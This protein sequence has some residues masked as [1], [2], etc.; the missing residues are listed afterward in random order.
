MM[1]L[2]PPPRS[3]RIELGTARVSELRA[4]GLD[5]PKSPDRVMDAGLG[6]ARADERRSGGNPAG[7]VRRLTREARELGRNVRTAGVGGHGSSRRRR[8]AAGARLGGAGARRGSRVRAEGGE[9]QAGG[10]GKPAARV[11]RSP[12]DRRATAPP[13]RACLFEHG[14]PHAVRCPPPPDLRA[15]PPDVRASRASLPLPTQP[16]AI[17][18]VRAPRRHPKLCHQHPIRG[19]GT[20]GL[21]V[22]R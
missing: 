12:P 8:S 7:P 10:V 16:F 22:P 14:P 4:R 17:L 21:P 6:R 5:H 9:R 15:S 1:S 3:R 11:W 20:S 2:R 18:A 19:F 13:E